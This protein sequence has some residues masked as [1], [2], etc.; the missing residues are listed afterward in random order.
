MNIYCTEIGPSKFS[1][2]SLASIDTKGSISASVSAPDLNDVAIV[3][4]FLMLYV[5]SFNLLN[6]RTNSIPPPSITS[7]VAK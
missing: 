2:Y 1:W 7:S 4:L 5:A 6:K 3:G